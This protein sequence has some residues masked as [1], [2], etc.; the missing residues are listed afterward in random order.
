MPLFDGLFSAQPLLSSGLFAPNSKYRRPEAPA[1]C[2]SLAGD[3]KE[4]A[5][6]A[7]KKRKATSS[8]NGAQQTGNA[9]REPG[10]LDLKLAER[11]VKRFKKASKAAGAVE[12]GIAAEPGR[13]AASG[14]PG[15]SLPAAAATPPLH[16]ANAASVSG[17]GARVRGAQTANRRSSVP[18]G[19]QAKPSKRRKG[20]PAAAKRPS[21]AVGGKAAAAKTSAR[22][23]GL[24]AGGEGTG[25]PASQ[26]QGLAA[27]GIAAEAAR[28]AGGAAE[29]SPTAVLAA[30]ARREPQGTAQPRKWQR[31][32][33]G[34]LLQPPAVAGSPPTAVAAGQAAAVEPPGDAAAAEPAKPPRR[35]PQEEA[36]RLCRTVFVGNLPAA[37][38]V[39]RVRQTF[40]RWAAC[41]AFLYFIFQSSMLFALHVPFGCTHLR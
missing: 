4:V 37:I 7:K 24:Q 13:E 6:P 30:G 34:A 15:G 16:S 20:T 35:T 29:G 11:Q 18:A 17:E 10:Q 38:K 19:E 14:G 23:A 8:A 12:T 25:L 26:P 27:P 9:A 31:T 41:A 3:S 36:E 28:T 33:P 21:T 5:K 22:S 2:A 39:K 32:E 40:A 1:A